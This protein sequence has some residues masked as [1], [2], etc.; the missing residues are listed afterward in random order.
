MPAEIPGQL[1]EVHQYPITCTPT[2]PQDAALDN[3]RQ[4]EP[5]VQETAATSGRRRRLIGSAVNDPGLDCLKPRGRLCAFA[6]TRITG[7]GETQFGE[8]LLHEGRLAV[9]PGSTFGDV[10]E[11]HIRCSHARACERSEGTLERLQ[12][13]VRRHG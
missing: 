2:V 11:D 3:L 8:G 7:M 10:R 5:S 6:S 1:R 4:E 12:R 13:F 9:A